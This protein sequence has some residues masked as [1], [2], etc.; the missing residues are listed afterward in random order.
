MIKLYYEYIIKW[1]APMPPTPF[2][3]PFKGPKKGKNM[4]N[5]KNRKSHKTARERRYDISEG[6]K[7]TGR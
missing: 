5:M 6:R 4:E 3:G 2:K 7:M 1:A